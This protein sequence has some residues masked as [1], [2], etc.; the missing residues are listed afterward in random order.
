M[1]AA[2][3]RGEGD[4]FL[5]AMRVSPDSMDQAGVNVAAARTGVAFQE[6]VRAHLATLYP[7][8]IDEQIQVQ[9]GGLPLPARP[10]L[11]ARWL[12]ELF[13]SSHPGY[14]CSDLNSR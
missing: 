9:Q 14:R 6:T 2:V 3:S 8:L 1:A 13:D 7:L 5:A 12:P 10:G 11:G 4:F